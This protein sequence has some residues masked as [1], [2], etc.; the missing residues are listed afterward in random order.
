MDKLLKIT[1]VYDKMLTIC[2]NFRG[3]VATWFALQEKEKW[4]NVPMD[5]KR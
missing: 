3:R 1:I 4:M 2:E 5:E